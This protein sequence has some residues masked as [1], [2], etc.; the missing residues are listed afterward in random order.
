L[1]LARELSPTENLVFLILTIVIF[2]IFIVKQVRHQTHKPAAV[3]LAEEH[4]RAKYPDWKIVDYNVV[5]I[6]SAEAEKDE[7][8]VELFHERPGQKRIPG[9]NSVWRVHSGRR[10]ATETDER[11]GPGWR[12]PGRK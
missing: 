10:T 11:S 3:L 9:F 12:I 6:R 2:V 7:C 4:F 5:T 1:F 8:I